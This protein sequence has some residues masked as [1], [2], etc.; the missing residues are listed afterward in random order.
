MRRGQ[1]QG[2]HLSR[3]FRPDRGPPGSRRCESGQTRF[4]GSHQ[5]PSLSVKSGFEDIPPAVRQGSKHRTAR[6]KSRHQIG[7]SLGHSGKITSAA[8]MQ[9]DFFR[10]HQKAG[11]FPDDRVVLFPIGFLRFD[12]ID[13][14]EE[15]NLGGIGPRPH[16]LHTFRRQTRGASEEIGANSQTRMNELEM[17]TPSGNQPPGMERRPEPIRRAILLQNVQNMLACFVVLAQDPIPIFAHHGQAMHDDRLAPAQN[18]A[19]AAS[20]E[21][22]SQ[23]EVDAHL[24]AQPSFYHGSD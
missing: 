16:R 24:F 19:E 1:R 5:L 6:K 8:A 21:P 2:R 7:V 18:G 11:Q 14:F 17:G 12:Q 20:I 4:M 15:R 23:F 3:D 13:H 22:S 10:C 9:K